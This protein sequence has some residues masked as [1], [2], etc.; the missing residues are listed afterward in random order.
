MTTQIN[1]RMSD[2]LLA[3]VRKSSESL[4]F[5]NIQDFIRE[6]IREKLFGEPDITPE[7][8][9]LV[10]KLIKLSEDRK[11]YVN[12]GELFKKLRS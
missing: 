9:G 12:E 8:L 3:Q 11:L 10:K 4:G 2:K 5:E 1:L 7:E 6:T